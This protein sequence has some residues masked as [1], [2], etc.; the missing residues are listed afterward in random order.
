[1][2]QMIPEQQEENY[3]MFAVPPNQTEQK[4]DVGILEKTDPKFLVKELE[5]L[6]LGK[7]EDE[8]GVLVDTGEKKMNKKGAKSIISDVKSIVNQNT[9]LSNLDEEHI[10]KEVIFLGDIIINKLSMRW[11]EY[12]ID[13]SELSS[14]VLLVCHT[15]NCSLLRA[16]QNQERAWHRKMVHE[17]IFSGAGMQN[18]KQQK[19]SSLFNFWRR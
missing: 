13:K 1:M 18:Q 6:L 15:A 5:N 3:P 10:Q 2:E 16:W 9:I 14:I 12:E 7:E 8:N 19:Q 17:Q 4:D 11:K